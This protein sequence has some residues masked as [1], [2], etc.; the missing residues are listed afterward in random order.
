M[1]LERWDNNQFTPSLTK[2]HELSYRSN[3]KNNK[4]TQF[5]VACKH[6]IV[7][8]ICK[9]PDHATEKCFHLSKAQGIVLNEQQNLSYP[10]QQRY[11]NFNGHRNSNN[12][13]ARTIYNSFSN[14]NFL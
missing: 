7:Y 4:V 11:N 5:N 9:K 10:N 13:F 1:I 3:N 6:K 14:N 12:N 8:L 2:P